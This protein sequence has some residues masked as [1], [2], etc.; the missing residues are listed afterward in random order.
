MI[1]KKEGPPLGF[2]PIDVNHRPLAAPVI[3]KDT[4]DLQ[5]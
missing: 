4:G 5:Q 3:S 2:D 1:Y